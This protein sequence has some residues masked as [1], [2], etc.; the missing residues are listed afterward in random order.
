MGCVVRSVFQAEETARAMSER[1]REPQCALGCGVEGAELRTLR[2]GILED[3]E[4][5][6]EDLELEKQAGNGLV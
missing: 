4:C 1:Q 3:T 6:T 2:A 5:L